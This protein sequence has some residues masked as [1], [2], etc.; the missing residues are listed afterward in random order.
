[1]IIKAAFGDDQEVVNVHLMYSKVAIRF[2]IFAWKISADPAN[3]IG[4]LWYEYLPQ[5]NMIVYISADV[6]SNL[7]V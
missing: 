2:P 4:K 5:G 7:I 3:P 1:M 6:G